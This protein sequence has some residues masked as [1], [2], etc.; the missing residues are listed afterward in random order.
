[1]LSFTDYFEIISLAELFSTL[2]LI[3]E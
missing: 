2:K 1:M 3:V